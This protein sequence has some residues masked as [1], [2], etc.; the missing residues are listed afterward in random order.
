MGETELARRHLRG[1]LAVAPEDDDALAYLAFL[2]H[3]AP[4]KSRRILDMK[5]DVLAREGLGGVAVVQA[6]KSLSG[7]PGDLELHARLVE[8]CKQ[9]GQDPAPHLLAQGAIR[10]G[11]GKMKEARAFF[12]AAVAASPEPDHVIGQLLHTPGVAALIPRERL[13]EL[14]PRSRPPGAGSPRSAGK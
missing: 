10:M 6:R 13:E 3:P 4:P 9:C 2:D 14:R 11:Q 12:E 1:V 7:G 8:L 5:I